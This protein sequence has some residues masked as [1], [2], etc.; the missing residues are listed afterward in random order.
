MAYAIIEVGGKQY[1]VEKGDSLLVDRLDAEEGAKVSPRALLYRSDE[2]VFEGPALEK[3]KVDAV[4][5]EHVRGEKVRVFKYRPKKRYRRRA[6]HR[7]ALT[8]LEI[9]EIK[10][11]SARKRADGSEAGSASGSKSVAAKKEEQP[12][13]K[14]KA[15]PKAEVKPRAKPA[16]KAKPAAR[17]SAARKPKTKQEGKE[18]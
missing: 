2:I 16:E 3:V 6:G 18:S 14:P 9:R 7:S 10:T 1:R 8:R 5:A 17:R 11:S 4:V 15:K 12:E 13:Q